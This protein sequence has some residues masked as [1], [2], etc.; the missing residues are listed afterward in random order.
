MTSCMAAVEDAPTIESVGYT[1]YASQGSGPDVKTVIDNETAEINWTSGDAINVF[2]GTMS[3]GK[4]VTSQSGEVA[5]FNGSL[6][7]VTGGSNTEGNVYMWGVYPY[8]ASNTCEGSNVTITLPP[9][10]PAAENTFADGLFPQIA[11]SESFSMGFYNLCGG[12]RF[13]VSSPD[14]KCVTL[15]GNNDEVISGRVK[16]TM[17]SDSRPVVAEVVSGEKVIK[18]YAPG[19]G[20]FKP[21]VN[22]YLTVFPTTF[23]KGM[24]LTY[25]KSETCASYVYSKSYT[26]GRSVFSAF[27]NRDQGLNFVPTPLNDWGD[28]ERVEG[29]I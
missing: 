23:T 9:V 20:A 11:R 8:N 28:G 19:G 7:V 1:V 13:S 4:F 17:D 15:R 6:D 29:E 27:T 25:Y 5:E 10:Q 16:V 24:T 21:G 22:Y 2:F 26:L 12:F 18:M 3:S 14:I